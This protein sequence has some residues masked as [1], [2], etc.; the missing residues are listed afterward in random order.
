MKASKLG[1]LS[2]AIASIC[3]LGPF[4]LILLGLGSLGIGAAIGKYHWY[5]IAAALLLLTFA[6]GSYLKKKR[7]CDL[8]ACKMENKKITLFTLIISTLI[9]AIF[10]TLNI[11]TYVVQ[12]DFT[13]KRTKA[14]LIE[15]RT[16]VIPV[17][18][19]TCFTCELAVSSAIKKVKGVV[20]AKASAK[21]G[22]ARVEYDPSKTSI[23]QL[24]E[25]INKTGYKA[26]LIRNTNDINNGNEI[27][28]F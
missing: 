28:D 21:E 9:V 3:C 12:K 5:F 10:V 4:V 25:A 19:M 17:E 26:S 15:T 2:A 23:E 11:Y 18:G 1:I 24:V 7:A 20:T 14:G 6:W 13:D 22:K 16:V 8:K 27:K